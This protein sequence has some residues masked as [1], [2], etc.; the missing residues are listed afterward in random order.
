[1]P[2]EEIRPDTGAPV[3]GCTLDQPR[4]RG[5]LE[6]LHREAARQRLA[7]ARF[8]L[9]EVLGSLLGVGGAGS[10]AAQAAA[11]RE[12]YLPL[13]EKQG[14][15]AYAM[16]RALAARRVVEFGTSF[17][18]S[19]TYLAAAVRDNG[20]G[21]VIGSELESGKVRAARA[22]LVEAGLDDLVEIREGD[23]R[24]T[25][26]DPGGTVDFLLLDGWKELYLPMVQLLAPHLRGGALV[27]ADNVFTFYRTLA[28][29]VAWVQDPAHGFRALTLALGDGMECAVRL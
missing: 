29:F 15:F 5:V 23:A 11:A 1:M 27:L 21:L 12:L 28:P 4:V 24:E 26:R 3:A 19:T 6:R 18:V 17:G 14:L 9:R 22:N 13:G 7:V 8:G 25:L 16:V 20:G 10:A 2:E